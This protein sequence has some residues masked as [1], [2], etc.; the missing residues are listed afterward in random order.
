MHN[1][2]NKLSCIGG[3]DYMNLFSKSEL[4]KM[5]EFINEKSKNIQM[6]LR[7][8]SKTKSEIDKELETLNNICKIIS[9]RSFR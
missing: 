1:K 4:I 3:L 2:Y 9:K 8:G 6:D 7:N 5:K